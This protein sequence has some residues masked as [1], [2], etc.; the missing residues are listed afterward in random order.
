MSRTGCAG[1]P[2]GKKFEEEL[3]LVKV[4]EPKRYKAVVSI[5]G[6]SYEYTRRFL[7]FRERKKQRKCKPDSAQTEI[8]GWCDL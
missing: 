2:F 1:C 7:E 8:K 3:E 4:F 5:F 6:Q